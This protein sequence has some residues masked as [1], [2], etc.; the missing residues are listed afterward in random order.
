MSDV[1]SKVI[2]ENSIIQFIAEHYWGYSKKLIENG[3][4]KIQY[5]YK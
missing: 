2:K 4:I 5:Q 1:N 3:N